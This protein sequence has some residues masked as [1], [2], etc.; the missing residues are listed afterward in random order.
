MDSATPIYVLIVEDDPN[1]A[2][3]LKESLIASG[4]AKFSIHI[5]DRLEEAME[6]IRSIRVD[7]VIL[8]LGLP[9]SS[10][11]STLDGLVKIT[12]SIPIIV[13][14]GTGG[15]NLGPISLDRGATDYITKD[16]SMS[17]HAPKAVFTAHHRRM[18]TQPVDPSHGLDNHPAMRSL[19]EVQF[20]LQSWL[21]QRK[22]D[23]SKRA[24]TDD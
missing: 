10:G 6:C 8:D 14:T 11:L 18:T 23:K 17:L 20:S 16:G 12:G 1:F 7:A 5:V 19:T 9:D 15:A 4:M 3:M 13:C 22:K 21:D 2:K 24:E